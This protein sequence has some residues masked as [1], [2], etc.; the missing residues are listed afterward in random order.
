LLKLKS[1]VKQTES[2]DDFEEEKIE[3]LTKEE[4]TKNCAK[5]MTNFHK[6]LLNKS[7][8]SAK[9]DYAAGSDDQESS[10]RGKARL[11]L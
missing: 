4:E 9:Y 3:P 1:L 7:S 5:T 6:P 10:E 11:Q 8:N 2:F